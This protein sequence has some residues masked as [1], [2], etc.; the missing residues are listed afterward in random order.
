MAFCTGC[1]C[2]LVNGSKFCHGCGKPTSS[3]SVGYETQPKTVEESTVHR[4]S[5][6]EQSF[7]LRKT[8]EIKEGFGNVIFTAKSEGFPK[9]PVIGLYDKRDNRVGYVA[10]KAFANTMLGTPECEIYY[11]DKC[12]ASLIRR[13]SLKPKYEIPENGWS[14]DM[15]VLSCTAYNG[16]GKPVVQISKTISARKDRFVVDVTGKKNDVL[17]VLLTMAQVVLVDMR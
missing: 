13:Y 6:I 10:K 4:L 1:G 17:A 16:R 9:F 14:F 12:I 8:F 5:I 15:G 2:E 7:T 11:K 3:G